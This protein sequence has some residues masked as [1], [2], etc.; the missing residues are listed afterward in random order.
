MSG[1]VDT[2]FVKCIAR[3]SRDVISTVKWVEGINRKGV[4]LITEDGF[5]SLNEYKKMGV[6]KTQFL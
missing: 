3:I 5:L 1:D 6:L 4:T 2:V